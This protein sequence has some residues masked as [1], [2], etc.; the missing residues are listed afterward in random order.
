MTLWQQ[1]ENRLETDNQYQIEH[2]ELVKRIR[3]C[4]FKE[5]FTQCAIWAAGEV[6]QPLPEG[7][8]GPYLGTLDD[9]IDIEDLSVDTLKCIIEDCDSFMS[10]EAWISADDSEEKDIDEQGG[11]DFLLTRDGHG[12]GFWDGDWEEPHGTA[13]TEWSKTFGEFYFDELFD[14]YTNHPNAK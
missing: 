6:H 7:E 13:L 5:S 3:H 2:E 11:H 1:H 12:A 14:D 10:G 8:D 9:I 4:T